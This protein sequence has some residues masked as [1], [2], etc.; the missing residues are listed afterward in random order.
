MSLLAEE[1]VEEWLNRNGFFSIRGVKLGVQEIDLLAIGLVGGDLVRR[2]I[3][4]SVSVRPISY[5]TGL[6][7]DTQKATGRGPAN[8]RRR[9]SEEVRVGVGEWVEKKYNLP[10]KKQLLQ[11]LAPGDWTNELVVHKVKF[12]EELEVIRS[13]G[14]VIHQLSDIVASIRDGESVILGASGSDLVELVQLA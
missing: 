13:H 14:I 3:E 4:V 2:H 5:L 10:R 8:P 1:L 7:K 11:M 12:P 6:P 9:T